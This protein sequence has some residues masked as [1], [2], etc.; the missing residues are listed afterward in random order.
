MKTIRATSILFIMALIFGGGLCATVNVD[1]SKM[2]SK[3]IGALAMT[4]YNKRYAE[5][6]NRAELPNLSNAEK[7]DLQDLKGVL[8]DIYPHIKSYNTVTDNG[9]DPSA[10]DRQALMNFI[11][12]YYYRE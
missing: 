8:I 11:R 7:Q 5:H 6:L 2:D 10:A 1:L 12:N 4:I 9:F 3:D